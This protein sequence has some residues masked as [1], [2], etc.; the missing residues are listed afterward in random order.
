MELL[1]ILNASRNPTSPSSAR[2]CAQVPPDS[3]KALSFSYVHV[4]LAPAGSK[5]KT[6][7]CQNSA[8]KTFACQNSAC[9]TFACK[10][11]ACKP[12][13]ARKHFGTTMGFKNLP[14]RAPMGAQ[15]RSNGAK[16]APR[17]DH[18]GQKNEKKEDP[19]KNPQGLVSA[20]ISF[21]GRILVDF[22]CQNRAKLAP[23]WN[24]RSS[25]L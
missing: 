23:K 11:S 16:M 5:T 22:G 14:N 13:I 1:K 25:S 15:R 7:A 19:T 8:C 2:A 20:V 12:Q 4:L 17:W 6:S 21:F 18:D 9:K 3:A 10:N 24:Q